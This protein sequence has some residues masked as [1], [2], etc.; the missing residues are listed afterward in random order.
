MRHCRLFLDCSALPA[1]IQSVASWAARLGLDR[2]KTKTIKGYVCGLRSAHIDRGYFDYAAFD[3]LLLRR[4]IR[5]IKRRQGDGV[6]REGTHDVLLNV[7]STSDASTRSGA[8]L[9]AAF[10]L[11][12]AAFLGAG[13]FTWEMHDLNDADLPIGLLLDH[14]SGCLQTNP[15]WI[16]LPP[17]QIHPAKASLLR[18]PPPAMPV[19]P[20]PP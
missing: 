2:I 15:N 19:V 12:F 3:S 18:S 9:H 7:L 20:L 1:T 11:A 17:K 6:P 5:G 16:F 8:T 10:C 14:L 4:V 13:E